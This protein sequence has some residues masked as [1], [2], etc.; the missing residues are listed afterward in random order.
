VTRLPRLYPATLPGSHAYN[1]VNVNW[2][3]FFSV[4]G[5]NVAVDFLIVL[6]NNDAPLSSSMMLE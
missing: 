2:W 4:G 5:A 3:L 1:G 6:R